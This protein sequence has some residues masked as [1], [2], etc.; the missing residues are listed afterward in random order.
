[1]KL[2]IAVFALLIANSC[3]KSSSPVNDAPTPSLS[4]SDV[5]M[6]EGNSATSNFE[7]VAK[8]SNSTSR[9]VTVTYSLVE[10]TA[11]A[12]EDFVAVTNQTVTFQ[13]NE[14]TKKIIVSVVGD[15]LKE[16]DDVFTLVVNSATNAKAPLT[17]STATILNDDTKVPFTNAGYD[18]PASYPGYTLAWSDEFN[19][20]SLNQSN[21]SFQ[22]GNGCP[23]L[24]GWGN[25]ELESYSENNLILQDGK[26]IIEARKE[27][28]IYTSSKIV[29][30]GKK[31]FKF[32]RI[33]IR[34]KLPKGKGIW[35]ALWLM[36]ESSVYGNW[37]RSGELDM[38]EMLG[39]EPNKV[40]G[41]LHYGP[42]PGSIQ[43]GKNFTL[44]T[45][46]FS[47]EFHVFSLIW[48]QDQIQWLIDGNVY[49]TANKAD[50]GANN[51]PFNEQFYFIFNV[52]VGGQW[53]GNPDAST[54][55]P[56]WMIV[57][58]V[59]VYQ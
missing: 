38:M 53:P 31:T 29:S 42:G 14:T 8:L 22:N 39:H 48:K 47:D 15:D 11:K 50:F 57:D 12:G 24:C 41:T 30:T 35:P 23:N 43:I 59:R 7:F 3:K 54:Y 9:E 45:G 51:Y 6:P 56:Q 4:V 58:Y 36:P 19:G 49:G 27:G 40:Y 20:T 33:D 25:N 44:P 16:G 2:A 26:M 1:M 34:A 10:G 52:A 32:G 55:F 18:A 37:P 17:A 21:W 46:S 5:S 28:S 13:P